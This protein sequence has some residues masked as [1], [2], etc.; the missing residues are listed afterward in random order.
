MNPID[1]LDGAMI[2]L[3]MYVMN[4]VHPGHFLEREHTFYDGS[5]W[6]GD[7]GDETDYG[8]KPNAGIRYVSF[9]FMEHEPYQ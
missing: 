1:V 7:F 6:P 8:L 5:R 2:V 3:A 4:F 9:K